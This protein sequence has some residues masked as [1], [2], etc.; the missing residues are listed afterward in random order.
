M[1]SNG[2]S[3]IPV[4]DRDQFNL[5]RRNLIVRLVCTDTSSASQFYKRAPVILMIE[6]AVHT[7]V[8]I[9]MDRTWNLH[10]AP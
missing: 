2:S 4:W 10:K 8:K 3:R 1:G 7:E 9:N 6:P 5:S